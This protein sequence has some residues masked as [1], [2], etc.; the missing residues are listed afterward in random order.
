MPLSGIATI[1]TLRCFHIF[2][3]RTST[4]N[5][6][7]LTGEQSFH[8]QSVDEPPHELT[9]NLELS[10]VFLFPAVYN[11]YMIIIL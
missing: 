3:R 8:P 7:L 1:Y 10:I 2:M 6:S 9:L 5:S 11:T 4:P